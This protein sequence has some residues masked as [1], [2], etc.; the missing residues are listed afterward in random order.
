[1]PVPT[2]AFVDSLASTW[3]IDVDDVRRKIT[4]KTKA[5]MAV[6][7]Y[8]L[9]CDMDKLVSLC[10]EYDLRLIE[11]CAEAFGSYYKGRH[12]GTFGD[13]ATFS[14]FGN[15]TITTGEGGMVVSRDPKAAARHGVP[16][17]DTRAYRASANTGTRWWHT[18]TG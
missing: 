12:V 16:A 3:Q 10:S 17:Q 11:D 8:G 1:M 9:P 5:V 7:L 2:P 14:F 13:I 18:T 4:H 6:H 15:K